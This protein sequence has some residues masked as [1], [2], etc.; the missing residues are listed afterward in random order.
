ML[1]TDGKQTEAGDFIRPE[2]IA[3]QIRAKGINILV[4]GV[5][6]HADEKELLAIAGPYDNWR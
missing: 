2:I 4:V 1:I 5:G 6:D 3:K